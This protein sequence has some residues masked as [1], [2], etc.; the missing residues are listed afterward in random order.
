MS[1]KTQVEAPA[2]QVTIFGGG[3]SKEVRRVKEIRGGEPDPGVF[4]ME[5]KRHTGGLS[6]PPPPPSEHTQKGPCEDTAGRSHLQA[7]EGG[8]ARPSLDLRL[9]DARTLRKQIPVVPATLSVIFLLLLGE[10]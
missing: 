4:F 8:P 3:A 9:P 5:E 1:S 6:L 10:P 2:L 7:E